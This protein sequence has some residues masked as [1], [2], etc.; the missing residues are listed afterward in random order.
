MGSFIGGA[1]LLLFVLRKEGRNERYGRT[2]TYV[3]NK[4][5][6]ENGQ[7]KCYRYMQDS[8]C[9][10]SAAKLHSILFYSIL[11]YSMVNLI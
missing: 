3:Q 5:P 8:Y 6:E 4:H 1:N 11:F 10:R 2:G 9:W 7:R